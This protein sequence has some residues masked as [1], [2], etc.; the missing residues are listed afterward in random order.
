VRPGYDFLSIALVP[1]GFFSPLA[2]LCWT[3]RSERAD[4]ME[5]PD[6]YEFLQISAN[7]DP[8]TIHRVYR[9]LAARFHPDNPETRDDEKFFLLTQAYSVLSSAERRAEYDAKR[10]STAPPA[11][12][13]SSTIDFMDDVKGEMNRRLGMLAVLYFQ[14]RSNPYSPDVSFLEIEE[15][16]GFPREYLEFTA[17]YLKSK[18]YVERS[19]SS[20]FTLTAE[21]VD[22]VETQR[23]NI[24]ILNKLLTTASVVSRRAGPDGS[25]LTSQSRHAPVPSVPDDHGVKATTEK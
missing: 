22:F 8:D 20:D 1:V 7:A 6:Y 12:P 3:L 10:K 19:D 16:L 25:P 9:F 14:R 24:P 13:L 18:G 15:R 21:G 4:V 23:V 2:P 11:A 17:W 5:V